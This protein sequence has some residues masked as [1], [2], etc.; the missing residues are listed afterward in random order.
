MTKSVSVEL[1]KVD[2]DNS[3]QY[4][5]TANIFFD[6]DSYNFESHR[7]NLFEIVC[8][9]IEHVDELTDDQKES[10]K[11]FAERYIENNIKDF[12]S[13]E[14]KKYYIEYFLCDEN[15][16]LADDKWLFIISFK[17]IKEET[18]NEKESNV[19]HDPSIF[20]PWC[21]GPGTD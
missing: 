12:R 3:L 14:N 19:Q 18:H 20:L 5:S 2:K 8:R 11:E 10:F 4:F 16:S 7:D 13:I 21:K 1:Y 17:M 15:N 9:S 6:I